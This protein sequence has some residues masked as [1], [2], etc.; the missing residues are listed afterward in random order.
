MKRIFKITMIFF[1]LAM[2][3]LLEPQTLQA[4]PVDTVGYI[5]NVK[6]ETVVLVCNNIRR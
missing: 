4:Q 2:S 1:A 5:Q 3:L 6:T